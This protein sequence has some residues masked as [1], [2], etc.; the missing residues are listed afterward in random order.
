MHRM[1][2]SRVHNVLGVQLYENNACALL[3]HILS[4][5]NSDLLQHARSVRGVYEFKLLQLHQLSPM[6]ASAL[7][8][9]LQRTLDS[10]RQTISC[11][12]GS[13]CYVDV[14]SL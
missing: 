10:F 2:H 13:I 9:Q 6:L 1:L 11:K 7:Q 4:I 14:L 8:Y 5:L 12:I 3:S